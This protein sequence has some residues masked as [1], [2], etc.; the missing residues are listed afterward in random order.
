MAVRKKKILLLASHL[1]K[2]DDDYFALIMK[3]LVSSRD[4][5]VE[6]LPIHTMFAD[7]RIIEKIKSMRIRIIDLRNQGGDAKGINRI[8]EIIGSGYD[9]IFFEN[10]YTAKYYLPYVLEYSP[11]SVTVVYN[12]K[13]HYLAYLKL[14]GSASS[15]AFYSMLT[16]GIESARNLEIPIYNYTDMLIFKDEDWLPAVLD[17]A[18]FV[19]FVRFPLLRGRKNEREAE[20]KIKAV[21]SGLRKR[22]KPVKKKGVSLALIENGLPVSHF[23]DIHRGSS[24][25]PNIKETREY[26]S[27]NGG[28]GA[29]LINEAMKNCSSEYLFIIGSNYY[30]PKETLKKLM[31]CMGTHPDIA[32]SVPIADLSSVVPPHY[33]N[34][35]NFSIFMKK[36]SAANFG[37][38]ED[39]KYISFPCFIICNRIRERL[40]IL[41]ERFKT[42]ET[43]LLD[44]SLRMFQAG[45]RIKM[46]KEAFVYDDLIFSGSV[47]PG[48]SNHHV[49][50]KADRDK[51]LLLE[52][53]GKKSAVFLESLDE[54]KAAASPQGIEDHGGTAGE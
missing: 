34:R 42:V 23:Y 45:Y 47:I 6:F 17:E 32:V 37:E 3:T 26:R 27:V 31:F 43:A 36:H 50:G 22:K 12:D 25:I 10:Y 39:L 18:P 13:S 21:F 41:D 40:G 33:S 28:T 48:G 7:K 46:M 19:P 1:R 11:Q 51:Y 16:T 5:I 9:I 24:R 53:W 30:I 2:W 29:E 52:K 20:R 15:S 4:Y 44:Y 8:E 38:W 49:C 35:E 14:S 54:K